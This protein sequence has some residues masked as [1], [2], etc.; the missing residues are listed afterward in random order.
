M[1]HYQTQ[2]SHSAFAQQYRGIPADTPLCSLRHRPFES[3]ETPRLTYPL[4]NSTPDISLIPAAEIPF[5]D[6]SCLTTSR[7]PYNR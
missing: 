3:W 6:N 7:T 4:F 1:F 2:I 5:Q